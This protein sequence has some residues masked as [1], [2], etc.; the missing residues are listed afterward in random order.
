MI[1]ATWAALALFL[2]PIGASAQTAQGPMI[3]EQ[4]HNGFLVAPDVKIT[5][6]DHQTSTLA[7]GYAGV[8]F[9]EHFFVGGGAYVLASHRRDRE[10]AYGG[11]VL[12]WLGPSAGAF[13]V[14]AKTLLGGGRAESSDV[15]T[16]VDRGRLVSSRFRVGQSFLVAEPEVDALVRFSRHLR[17]AVGASYRFTG[18][19]RGRDGLFDG[20]GGTGLDGA[21][22]S[23]GLQIVG[24]S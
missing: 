10:M 22:G 13:G 23:I 2:I 19:A 6:V 24:G 21:A 18:S 5:E 15:I 8:V 9:D 12:Q 11:L 7:G 17:L 20:R 4:V 1:R 16:V 14:S 3:V